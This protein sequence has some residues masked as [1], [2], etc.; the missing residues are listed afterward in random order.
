MAFVTELTIT[1]TLTTTNDF[2]G[3][4]AKRY[5][6]IL[7]SSAWMAKQDCFFP[8]VDKIYRLLS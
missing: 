4:A 8:Y 6:Q 5:L 2:T 7:Q 1:L 3:V